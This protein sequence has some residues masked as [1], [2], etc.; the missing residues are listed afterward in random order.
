MQGPLLTHPDLARAANVYYASVHFP[1]TV[2]VLVL[3]WALRPA[4]YR[5]TRTILAVVT[6]AALLVHLTFPLAP[7]RMLAADGMVDL[8]ARFGPAVYGPPNASEF[9]NQFAAMPS[10][11]VAWSI[12]VAVAVIRVVAT[13]WRRLALAHPALTL[14]VVVVT[15]NHY[16]LDGAAAGLLAAS[17]ATYRLGARAWPVRRVPERPRTTISIARRPASWPRSRPVANLVAT[18]ASSAGNGLRTQSSSP[19]VRHARLPG[20]PRLR[21]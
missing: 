1:L 18:T 8:A 13:R 16:W 3:L 6:F 4:E 12:V 17:F 2:A 14:T 7:P 15:G 11:H 21:R 9:S 20:G 19:W 10:L 5:R